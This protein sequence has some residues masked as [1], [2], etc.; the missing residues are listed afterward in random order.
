MLKINPPDWRLIASFLVVLMTLTAQPAYSNESI[1][2]DGLN[3]KLSNVQITKNIASMPLAFT[4]NQGQWDD[5]VSF[6]ANAN[7]ATMW[8]SPDGAYYQFTRSIPT[9]E[10]NADSVNPMYD[11]FDR[12]P[13]QYETM[14]IKASFMGANPNPRMIGV[15]MLNYKCNYF[16]GNDPNEWHTDVPNYSAVLY[17]QIY[18]GINLKYYGDGKK[19][20]YDFIVSPGADYSQIKIQYESAKSV[21]INANGQLVVETKWGEVVEQTP[22]IYQ[23]NNNS[24]ITVVG[25]YKIHDDNSFGFKLSS[26]NPDLPLVIDPILSYSTYLGGSSGD[27]GTGIAVDAS[28]NAYITGYTPSTNFPTEGE[29]QTYQGAGDV[30][31]TKLNSSGNSLVYSTYLGGSGSERG[32]GIAVNDSGNAYITGRTTSTDFP[33]EGEYQTYQGG[34]DAFVTKLNSFGNALAYSTYLG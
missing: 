10:L 13:I 14:M 25:E 23:L 8:F 27:F 18:D 26:Y 1:K 20:E 34:T 16:I 29:Y 31:V 19:M 24:R 17:E 9:D 4:K 21:T 15:E 11:R 3:G 28:G 6:R 2:A 32:T 12:E 5:K 22:V 30:F 33:T 7:G